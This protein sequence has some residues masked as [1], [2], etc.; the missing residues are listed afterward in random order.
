MGGF[1]EVV[2][3]VE[4]GRIRL[5][6]RIFASASD[7]TAMAMAMATEL[8]TSALYA[9]RVIGVTLSDIKVCLF[10]SSSL[11]KRFC[12]SYNGFLYI[13]TIFCTFSSSNFNETIKNTLARY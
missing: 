8:M 1:D 4:Q 6:R 5:R 10:K 9:F 3:G 13:S 11:S 2:L 7:T 12:F